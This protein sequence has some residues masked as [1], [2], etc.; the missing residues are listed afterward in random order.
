MQKNIAIIGLGQQTQQEIIPALLQCKDLFSV[1]AIC[2]PQID[3]ISLV[4]PLFPESKIYTNYIDLLNGERR[5]DN[6]VI[7][8]PHIHY[9]EIVKESLIRGIDIFKEK[10][11]SHNI[12]E[13]KEL[14]KLSEKKRL[15]IFT[16]TKRNYYQ[17]YKEGHEY[18]K[19][20][21]KIYQYIAKHFVTGGNIHYGWRSTFKDAGGGVLIN[22]GYHLIDIL[23]QYFGEINHAYMA[24]SNLGCPNNSYE[25]EDAATLLLKHKKGPYGSFQF[26]CYSGVKHESI[27]VHGTKGILI[28]KK[29][30]IQLFNEKG[31]LLINN[32]YQHDGIQANAE[33]LTLFFNNNHDIMKKNLNQNMRIMKTIDML[34]KNNHL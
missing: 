22:L 4:H 11:L 32:K 33:A 29:D 7:S 31:A 23:I 34:Y 21:G 1:V 15:S 30:G 16:I 19:R 13:A 28:I 20:I 27:E 18:L 25:V 2:D 5:I 3:Q 8:V 10:P 9:F 14:Y 6:I 17:S 12:V 24:S 26:N